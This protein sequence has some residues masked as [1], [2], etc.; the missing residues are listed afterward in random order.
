MA[1]NPV[2]SAGNTLGGTS[3]RLDTREFDA[4]LN[5]MEHKLPHIIAKVLSKIMSEAQFET[6]AYI[7]QRGDGS[8]SHIPDAG[9]R[10]AELY[11]RKDVFVRGTEIISGM[12]AQRALTS[13]DDDG[14]QFDL[15]QALQEGIMGRNVSFRSSGAAEK[16]RQ[17]G[18]RGS[19][20]P[21]TLSNPG[22]FF[23]HGYPKLSYIE[24]GMGIVER[25]LE[26]RIGS[27]IE[28]EFGPGS[29]YRG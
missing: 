29:Y 19:D 22:R 10:V 25:R 28:R 14:N 1:L 11:E 26:R 17:F 2:G 8:Q 6:R 5:D 15:A 24:F 16:G 20:T 7:Q 13:P 3:I 12:I 9:S 27:A 21:W 18:R 23:F 4:M